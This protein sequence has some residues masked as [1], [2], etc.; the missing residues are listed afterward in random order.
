MNCIC[1]EWKEN[2]GPLPGTLTKFNAS[3]CPWCGRKLSAINVGFLITLPK[4]RVEVYD[5]DGSKSDIPRV[6]RD[7]AE[8]IEV[9]IKI[10][11]VR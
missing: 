4:A 8:Q 3:F 10:G 11:A 6:L 1:D 5:F 7:A 2:I 9:A